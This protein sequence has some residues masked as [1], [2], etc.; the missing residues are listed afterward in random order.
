M[1]LFLCLD[2]TQFSTVWCPDRPTRLVDGEGGILSNLRGDLTMA[3]S[4]MQM[5]P[6]NFITGT[7][8][9]IGE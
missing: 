1:Q 5:G 4:K 2:S 7:T 3:I 9:T 8:T 6:S